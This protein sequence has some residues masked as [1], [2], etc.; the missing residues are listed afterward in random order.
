MY[1]DVIQAMPVNVDRDE[2]GNWRLV[3][4]PES[5]HLAVFR[6]RTLKVW[7]LARVDQKTVPNF[8]G[9]EISQSGLAFLEPEGD[10]LQTS[11]AP[12]VDGKS[13]GVQFDS[14][15][16][17]G[18]ALNRERTLSSES[19][20]VEGLPKFTSSRD[21]RIS[22]FVLAQAGTYS[23]QTYRIASNGELS[24]SK[25][26]M[27][28]PMGGFASLNAE[29]NL[30]WGGNGFYEVP[31]GKR[32][33]T[34]ER[35]DFAVPFDRVFVAKTCW[36]DNEHAVEVALFKKREE[37]G[38]L[39]QRCLVLWSARRA[40]PI[41]TVPAV[42]ALSVAA[43]GDGAL[44]AE[45]GEDGR[46]RIRD[47][48]TLQITQ[49]LRVHDQPVDV[50]A[51]HPKLPYLATCSQDLRVKIWNIETEE[52]LE[53]LGL[54]ER[55]PSQLHWSQD[56]RTLAVTMYGLRYFISPKSCQPKGK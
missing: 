12:S 48:K 23:L 49:T 50:V 46:V 6:G 22:A 4:H 2:G 20:M 25:N 53:E 31:S 42:N 7:N 3:L 15:R 41:V 44:V 52:L 35:R 5:S 8:V 14:F 33:Q 19:L 36:T 47:G 40:E 32:I 54:F 16:I 37:E 1:G 45:G 27:Y 24:G 28:A 9:N 11:P 13:K 56:G 30:F 29:G 55:P 38:A 43:S 51:W 10:V 21:G 26:P 17:Q 34:T 39:S 18:T